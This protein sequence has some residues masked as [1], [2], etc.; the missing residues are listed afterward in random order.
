MQGSG[1]GRQSPKRK[2]MRIEA[3][4]SLP[5]ATPARIVVAVVVAYL[6]NALLVSGDG[7]DASVAWAE[8]G[9]ASADS[10]GG[11]GDH[12]LARARKHLASNSR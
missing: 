1:R 11:E 7:G 4:T 9:N 2:A 8:S 6:T 10:A 12:P 3:M 5:R